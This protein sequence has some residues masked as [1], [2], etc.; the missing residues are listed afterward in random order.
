MDLLRSS[1]LKARAAS[2]TV[3]A[4]YLTHLSYNGYIFLSTMIQT[5]GLKNLPFPR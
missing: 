2:K 5:H 3:L 4:S 1:G